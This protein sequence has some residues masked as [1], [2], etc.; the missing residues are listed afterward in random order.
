MSS[1]D[2]KILKFNQYQ[3]SDKAQFIF[4]GD[5]ECLIEKIDGCKNNPE[6]SFTAKVS[7]R[8]P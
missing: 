6:S 5:L 8:I 3:K 4:Y 7:E 2:T 1:V